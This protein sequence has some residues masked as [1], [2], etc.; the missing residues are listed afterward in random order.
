VPIADDLLFCQTSGMER[1]FT[2]ALERALDEAACW[3]SHEGGDELAP[4]AVLLGLLA[5]PECRAAIILARH[6]IDAEAVRRHWPGLRKRR[7]TPDAGLPAAPNS[8][9]MEASYSAAA[10]RLVGIPSPLVL[11][12]EHLLLG[13]ASADHEAAVWLRRQGLDPDAMEADIRRQCGGLSCSDVVG[14][15]L[16]LEP[17]VDN[18]PA[19]GEPVTAAEGA[20]GAEASDVPGACAWSSAAIAPQEQVRVLRILDAAAN[21]CQEGLRV[22][23][24]YVRFVLDDRHLT[25]Q[26]KELRHALTEVLARLPLH[27]RLTARETLADVGVHLSTPSEQ[28]RTSAAHVLSANFSRLREAMRSLEEFGKV[29][30]P[31]LSAQVEQL[32]YR[33]YT[34]HRAVDITAASLQRLADARLYVLVDGRE[35]VADLVAMAQ[36]LVDAGVHVIQLRDKHLDD[37]RLLERARALRAV[38]GAGPTLFIVNDRPDLAALSG[39]DG[40]HVGQG[41]LTVKDA[42][43]IVGPSALVGVSTHSIEQARQAVFD[44]ASYIGVGPTF[45]SGTKHFDRFP[46]LALLREVAA[47]IRLP[48]F[49]IGGIGRDNLAQV[50]ATGVRRVAVSHS[51][52]TASD[53]AAAARAMLEAMEG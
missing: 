9:D 2:P 27:E 53:P 41:E 30:D 23:E 39:A 8:D 7:P 28:I 38:T 20:A 18:A 19:A 33:A 45:P 3:S 32:R 12:T 6:G 11:A 43:T 31:A 51:V 1:H 26:L 35:S 15:P 34:L 42:R 29:L 48:A 24:D 16:L 52:A 49:A 47:E 13:L 25:A 14:D 44:G 10:A 46:G 5:E 36:A 22:V 50:L 37:R 17:S 21:R 40:V 4:P